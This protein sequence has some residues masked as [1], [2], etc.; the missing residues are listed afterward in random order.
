MVSAAAMQPGQIGDIGGIVESGALVYDGEFFRCLP[1]N[2][3]IFQVLRNVPGAALLGVRGG[4]LSGCEEGTQ[5]GVD[6]VAVRK[7]F[8]HVGCEQHDIGASAKLLNIFAAHARRELLEIEVR[9]ELVQVFLLIGWIV[10][11]A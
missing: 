4:G 9:R 5:R 1:S 3:A 2:P 7:V 6:G 11:N 10:H 8:H